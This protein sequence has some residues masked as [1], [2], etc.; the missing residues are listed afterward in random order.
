LR[1]DVRLPNGE[2]IKNVPEGM[3][4]ADLVARLRRNGYDMSWVDGPS[5]PSAAAPQEEAAPVESPGIGTRLKNAFGFAS[6]EEEQQ[7]ADAYDR[8]DRGVMNDVGNL[9]KRSGAKLLKGVTELPSAIAAG[10]GRVLGSA[11]PNSGVPEAGIGQALGRARP[12]A[13]DGSLFGGLN[14]MGLQFELGRK[15][16]EEELLAAQQKWDEENAAKT[17]Q[18]RVQEAVGN[19]V[20]DRMSSAFRRAAEPITESRPVV[21]TR[22][23][24]AGK[25]QEALDALSP[26]VRRAIELSLVE[27]DEEEGLSL[28]EGASDP[29]WWTANIIDL[30]TQMAPGMAATGLSARMTYAAKYRQTL[31]E[32]STQKIPQSVAIKAAEKEALKAAKRSAIIAGGLTEGGVA[33]GA[34]ASQIRETI[35]SLNEETLMAYPGYMELRD[36]GMTHEQAREEVAKDKAAAVA[37]STGALVGITGAPMNAYFGQL[38]AKFGRVAKAPTKLERLKIAGKG[39]LGEGAQEFVQ[40]AGEQIIGNV[41]EA[42]ITGVDTWDGVLEN[43]I[44]GFV[45]GGVVGGGADLAVSGKQG[46]APAEP[47]PGEAPAPKGP[48]ETAEAAYE[49]ASKALGQGEITSRDPAIKVKYADIQKLRDAKKK[50]LVDFTREL[51]HSGQIKDADQPKVSEAL[52]QAEA[53]GIT[54]TSRKTP[55]GDVSP[56]RD[57]ALEAVANAEMLDETDANDLIANKLAKV[58]PAGNMIL[59]PAGRRARKEAQARAEK[60][61][62]TAQVAAVV[63]K[64]ATKP[65]QVKK[66]KIALPPEKRAIAAEKATQRALRKAK[67]AIELAAEKAGIAAK[68][69]DAFKAGVQRQVEGAEQTANEIAGAGIETANPQMRDA[70]KAALDRSRRAR[71]GLPDKNT[72]IAAFRLKG[73]PETAEIPGQ[74]KVKVE[75]VKAAKDIATAYR[76]K[77]G[78]TAPEPTEYAKVDPV[79]AKKIAKAFDEMKH[80]PNNPEVK[81]AY[82]AMIDETKAQWD[83]IKK[84]GLKVE[85][86]KPGQKDPYAASPRMAIEDVRK[87]NHLWVYPTDSGFGSDDKFAKDN[88]MLEDTGEI[89]SGHKLKANDVFRIVHDYFG[90]VQ[91]ANGFR[92]DG[93]ENAWRVHASMYSPLAR[94]A[95][96]TETR[97]QNSWVNYGP[98]GESNRKASAGETVYAD[99]KIGLLPAEFSAFPGETL[100]FKHFSNMSDDALDLDPEKM[101]TGA[102]GAEAK[103]GGPKVISLYSED[104]EV[105]PDV[106]QGRTRYNVEIPKEDLYD[107][108]VDAQG[109]LRQAQVPFGMTT[110]KDGNTVP[111]GTRFDMNR[112]EELVRDAG[113]L[114]YHTPEAS[115]ILKG[116]ARIFHKYPATRADRVAQRQVEVAARMKRK[117]SEEKVRGLLTPEENARLKKASAKKLIEV[118]DELPDGAELAAS[119]VAGQAKRGWYRRSSEALVNVFGPDAPRFAAL[120]AA[121]SPQTSVEWNFRNAVAVW[122][123]WEKAG[124]PTD[125]KKIEFVMRNNMFPSTSRVGKANVLPAWINNTVKALST[126]DPTN[127]TLSGPKVD[128]FAANLRGETERVTLD[129]WMANW[130]GVNQTLFKG[131]MTKDETNPGMRPGYLAYAAR[132]REAAQ[133]LTERTGET[134][135]A[136]EVQETVWSWAKTLYEEAESYG[137][138]AT[139]REILD[140]KELTD[141]LINATPDFAGLFEDPTIAA[142]LRGTVY[143]PRAARSAGEAAA[144]GR[145]GRK[146]APAPEDAGYLRKAA[147]RLDALRQA[148]KAAEAETREEGA[149]RVSDTPTKGIARAE[150]DAVAARVEKELGVSAQIA[151]TQADLPGYIQD[152]IP[153]DASVT[154]MFVEDSVT[155]ETEIWFVR[156]NIDTRFEAYENALHE[157]VGHMGLRAVLGKSYHRVMADIRASFPEKVRWA[158]KQNKIDV[159]LKAARAAGDMAAV[160][161]LESLAAEELIAYAAGQVL[162]KRGALSKQSVWRRIVAKVRDILRGVGLLNTYSG[163]DIEALIYRARDY[164]RKSAVTRAQEIAYQGRM[165]AAMKT[166]T[167]DAPQWYDVEDDLNPN[168]ELEG[169]EPKAGPVNEQIVFPPGFDNI[170]SGNDAFYGQTTVEAY[171][172]GKNIGYVTLSE[173]RVADDGWSA[174][175]VYVHPDYRG[176][177]VAQRMYKAVSDKLGV[178]PKPANAQTGLGARMW[179]SFRKRDVAFRMK[180]RPQTQTEAFKEWFKNSKVRDA[181]GEPLVVYHGTKAPIDFDVFHTG[182]LSYN[183]DGQELGAHFGTA[184]AA[185]ERLTISSWAEGV[186]GG[187]PRRLI[188]V[189]LSIQNPIRLK[190][191]GQWGFFSLQDDLRAAGVDL[192]GVKL[193]PMTGRRHTPAELE[194]TNEQMRDAI[195]AA[196]YD[197][198]V[199]ANTFEGKRK[200][201]KEEV[202]ALLPQMKLRIT[203]MTDGTEYQG[204]IPGLEGA[205]DHYAGVGSVFDIDKTMTEEQAREIINESARKYLSANAVIPTD[206]YIVFDPKQIKSAVGNKGTFNPTLPN[207]AFAFKQGPTG[208]PDLDSFISKIGASPLTLRERWSNFKEDLQDRGIMALFDEF[209]GIKR[210]GQL[211][212]ISAGDSGYIDARLSKNAAELTQTIIE[213]GPPVWDDGAPNVGNGMGLLSILKPLKGNVNLWL[214]YM[215]A[216]RAD[217]LM[218]EGRER[219]FNQTEINAALDLARQH[220]EFDVARAQYNQL[221]KQVLDFA[222]QSGIINAQGRALWEHADYIPFHRL[223]EGGEVRASTSGGGGIGFVRNQI[224][225]LTGGKQKIGDPLENIIRNWLALMD[226]SLKANAAR[227]TVDGLNGTG[228]VTPHK[229]AIPAAPV[230]PFAQARQFLAANPQLAQTMSAIGLNPAALSPQAFAGLQQMMAQTA[231]VEDDVISVWRGGRRE[232]WKVHDPLLMRSLQN[233]HSKAWAPIIK[234]LTYPKRIVTK[235]ITLTPQFMVKNFWRDVW[236]VFVQG[237]VSSTGQK[238][239]VLPTDSLKG[240]VSTLRNDATAKGLL[241]GGGSFTEGYVNGGDLQ[242]ATKIIRRSVNRGK[243]R[244]VV[245]DSPMK[246]WRFYRDLQNAAENANRVAMYNK[247]RAAGLSRKEAVFAARDLLDF[248]MRGNNPIVQLIVMSTPFMNARLQGLY[249]L[250]RGLKEDFV[251]VAM[252]GMLLTAATMALL[253]KNYDDERYRALSDQ[254]KT[255]NWHFFDVFEEGDHFQLPKPFE[256]GSIF[257][258]IPEAIGDAMFTNSEEPDGTLQ[259]AKLVG[260]TFAHTL[261]LSPQPQAVWPLLELAINKDTFTQSPILTQ[262]DESVLPEDQRGPRTSA[263]YDMLAQAMPDTAPESLRSPKQLEHLGRGYLGNLQ[264]Y[265]L[266][267]SDQI[268]RESRGEPAPPEK[269]TQDIPGVRDF[270]KTGPSRN[271]RHIIEMYNLADEA[272]KITSSIKRNEDAETTEGDARAEKLETENAPL[273]D[274]ADDF[275]DAAKEVTDLKKE[276]RQI[277]LDKDLT[278]EQKREALDEIQMEINEIAKD[279]YDLRPGGKL[280]PETAALLLTSPPSARATILRNNNMPATADLL[281]SF[282]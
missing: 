252:R 73:A 197:G 146:A 87:N 28:G 125:R 3:S 128:S 35:E 135:T 30:G 234:V 141:D 169:N 264:D 276:Q 265:V 111:V 216:R 24:A 83:E 144:A 40:E 58:G 175:Y 109:L 262:G 271:N 218:S 237:A 256:V 52:K 94:R 9:A 282:A 44:T 274:V 192:S 164:F 22:E 82:R 43:A 2:I 257:G 139:A 272:A 98:K 221:Q 177:G 123:G 194:R 176:K 23:W 145:A 137:A 278:P 60:S 161:R 110:D 170:M 267:V 74:G 241:A 140:N 260:Y 133:I 222:E 219:L 92:A 16:T 251:S 34:N 117:T 100:K 229:G 37:I 248:S 244:G 151:D 186:A 198:A 160:R 71:M 8:G 214:A 245:L 59:L 281:E 183:G 120:L 213:H 163:E 18:D 124:R 29:W 172:D 178:P 25:E 13:D 230:V 91:E 227:V 266:L 63:P 226:A 101:G 255:G 148:R 85:F 108:S 79:R 46:N 136:A 26:K 42:P 261:N 39:A 196:G 57:A 154:G 114:G 191:H 47:K 202:D 246:V 89:V 21:A 201:T 138:L 81:R 7:L 106:T 31:A 97:G 253:A 180:N 280:N 105:E 190:D 113:Y 153:N 204:Y 171:A 155:G 95:M 156:E 275:K 76:A 263:T 203:P 122:V 132:V 193:P 96:T 268:V 36:E 205:D 66:P 157:A 4:R 32:L 90:H 254:Q 206:S 211:A 126:D 11:D 187:L 107:A 242:G 235:G 62:K 174:E 48:V 86:I 179:D 228:L 6:D 50:A 10:T 45:L 150:L 5:Q 118:F 239:K 258:T 166:Q 80:E 15:P 167:A 279:V 27:H 173:D 270:Y 84:S 142:S 189:Y 212:G 143:G 88:P 277:Q 220:P 147:D 240:L 210:A 225:R 152:L 104:G 19:P 77:K 61:D 119:A 38:A 68:D 78:I 215:T 185:E 158:E 75:P 72:K 273:L 236:H 247:S 116:Q 238:I 41:A 14:D 162:A 65:V 49:A 134:W 56:A 184:E 64:K 224:K 67:P 182:V 269:A 195:I 249:R 20:A 129:A 54:A 130:A 208:S 17:P 33:G 99:Q 181:D 188:P 243:V 53:E 232:H 199:Y 102:K 112:F 223:V 55:G 93:E 233:I 168:P 70:F 12:A 250:G 51:L 69:S 207:I 115:G 200:R 103:R 159:E 217:R 1:V 259:A 127:I 149:L 209:H 165:A 231:P 131:G 121:L